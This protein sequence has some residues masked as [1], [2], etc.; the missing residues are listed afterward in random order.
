MRSRKQMTPGIKKCKEKY[1]GSKSSPYKAA[2]ANLVKG[3]GEVYQG[4]IDAVASSKTGAETWA[5]VAQDVTKSQMEKY[6]E[7]PI[8]PF[9]GNLSSDQQIKKNLEA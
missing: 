3:A 9:F 2:D 5:G 4:E 1:G 6:G 8:D 7:D